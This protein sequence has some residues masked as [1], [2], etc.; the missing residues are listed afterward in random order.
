MNKN[1]AHKENVM[2][3]KIAILM[4]LLLLIAS[5][6]SAAAQDGT[7]VDAIAA[8]AN[9]STMAG[10]IET[11]GLTETLSGEGPFTVFAPT[12]DAFAALPQPVV[13]YLT[14]HTNVLTRVLTY[15]VVPAADAAGAVASVEGSEL[16]VVMDETG[17]HVDNATVVTP[18]VAASNG[19][20]HVI[21]TV[22]MPAFELPAV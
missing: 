17:T 6:S 2:L 8:D 18:D 7:V 15:H 5:F 11:A 3:R 19:V 12:N 14:S 9:L 20:V 22:L 1:N 10:L 16:N 4:S 21:D 13:D